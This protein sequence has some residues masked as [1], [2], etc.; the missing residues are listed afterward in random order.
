[1]GTAGGIG[2]PPLALVYQDRSGPEIR[3]TLAVAF[4][5]G[6][7][8]SLVALFFVGKLEWEHV[9]L[10]LQLL[11]GLFLAPLAPGG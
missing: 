6:T 1:M 5:V 2:G 11:P 8:I 7:G 4:L 9:L 3:S 10:A